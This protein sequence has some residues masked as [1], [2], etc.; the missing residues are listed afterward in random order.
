[1]G[2]ENHFHLLVKPT[3]PICNLDCKYCYY[4]E[5][6]GY[7]PKNH[8]FH[9]S[10]DVLES[11]IR[12]YIASQDTEEI[13]FAWQGGEPTLMGEEF[14]SKA[15]FLQKKYANGKQIK[16]TIQTNGT[17]LNDNW[18]KLLSD[19]H[20]LVG[21]SL[22]GPEPIH[23][24][25]RVDRGGKP[26][27][28]QVMKGLSLLKKHQVEFNVL[29]CVTKDSAYKPLE[30]YHFFKQQGIQFMQFIPIVEQEKKEKAA[31]CSSQMEDSEKAVTHW[32]VEPDM[33]G[34]FLIQIFNEWVREDIGSVFVMNFE[35]ALAA[36][37]GIPSPVCI[38]AEECGRAAAM[39]HN[40][41]LF[42]CDHFVYPEY[43]LGNIQDGLMKIV[44]QPSQAAF[45][46]K[47][48]D[49]LPNVCLNCEFQFA[50]HGEC[51]KNRFAV[52]DE[53]EPGL[54]YLCTSYKKYFKHI[55]PYMI[56]IKQLLQAGLP[57]AL[58]K[59]I[60]LKS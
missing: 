39:E 38:F 11:Y 14:F 2:K 19:N 33:Y 30:I 47:K 23:N 45:G 4:T 43:R 13:I 6:E 7:Y 57:A 17:L 44:N 58:V 48:K 41:D 51:P 53:N 24:Q 1:M 15:I 56:V 32:T 5:K 49:T 35:W 27:F 31:T 37:A 20:F 29:T 9:M 8:S 40:G 25:S 12:Q 46:K 60:C 26:T 36:W 52:T 54:N 3:G 50:C 55:D 21:L 18:C 34:E 10:D 16:N 28:D 42:S 59:E 22:D